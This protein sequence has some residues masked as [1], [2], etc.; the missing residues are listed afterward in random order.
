MLCLY[1]EKS[2]VLG[3]VTPNRQPTFSWHDLSLEVSSVHVNVLGLDIPPNLTFN[4]A[5]LIDIYAKEPI[6]TFFICDAVL[7]RHYN[8]FQRRQ[9]AAKK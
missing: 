7:S 1:E 3:Y 5:H 6:L 4:V 9:I 2:F 8:F